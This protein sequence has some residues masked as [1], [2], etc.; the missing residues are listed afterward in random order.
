LNLAPTA[1]ILEFACGATSSLDQYSS[2]LTSDQLKDVFCQIEGNFVGLGIELRSQKRSLEIIS[3]ISG[4]PAAEAGLRAGDRIV[5]VDGIVTDQMSTDEAAELLKGAEGSWTELHLM[6]SEGA[7]RQVRLMRR[8]VEVPSIEKVHM[9]RSGVGDRLHQALQLPED[10]QP[11]SGRSAVETASTG[12]ADVG[13]R[14]ARQPGRSAE[15][16]GRSR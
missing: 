8:R 1:T 12:H 5:Q 4:S 11:R 14:F 7:V 6:D 10:D 16:R 15:R 9:V 2:F 13:D 3:V